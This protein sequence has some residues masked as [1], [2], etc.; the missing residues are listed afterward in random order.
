[1][2]IAVIGGGAAG[3]FA[4][5][6]CASF[7]PQ[8]EVTIFE[9]SNK[10][11]AKVK[12]SGGGRCNVTHNCLEVNKLLK[13]YPRGEKFLRNAFHSFAVA[14]TL[15]WFE[16]RGVALKA[17]ADGR[18]FP[19]SDDSQ[20]IID[21]LLQEAADSNIAIR[22]SADVQVLEPLANGQFRLQ[23][24]RTNEKTDKAAKNEIFDKVIVASGGSPKKEGLDW[25]QNLGHQ[26][27][28]PVPSLFT[29]NIPNNPITELMG[30]AVAQARVRVADTKLVQEGALLI[31]HW[32]LSAY[33]VLKLSAWGARILAEKNYQF[34]IFVSWLT[35]H[36]EDQL[37]A[38]IYVLKDSL[39]SRQ[40]GNKNPF[41]L[42]NRLWEFLLQKINVSLTQ[43]WADLT[44]PEINGLVNILLYD[45]YQ[46]QGKTTFKEEFVTCGGVD[47][48]DIDY[49]TMQSRKVVGLYFAG[50]VMDIDGVTGG[51]NFQAAWTTGY[52]A[53]QLMK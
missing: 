49:N 52:I 44:K 14:Q 24:G 6:S 16:R 50:E 53:G 51:F 2:K 5:L 20:T 29:F 42:P 11:L 45:T 12:I 46:V 26:I 27:Q 31:T 13:N 37:R 4:A 43:R 8:Y 15:A 21:C 28:L 1:M 33:A 35:S 17:E 36:H 47:L 10:L 48:A 23:I 32:G 34:K 18:I 7:Y 39:G 30:V 22:L 38:D 9:K 25:L 40:M 19:E 3:F 41:A